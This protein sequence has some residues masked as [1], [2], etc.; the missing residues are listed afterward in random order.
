MKSTYKVYNHNGTI[1]G[2][3]TPKA[4]ANKE[5]RDYTRAT[6]NAAYVKGV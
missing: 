3:F 6:G 4:K 1:L 2:E 5:E